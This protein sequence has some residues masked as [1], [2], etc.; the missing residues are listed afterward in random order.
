MLFVVLGCLEGKKLFR[1][2]KQF[3]RRVNSEEKRLV[4]RV[5]TVQ[6]KPRFFGK[7]DTAQR[8]GAVFRVHIRGCSENEKL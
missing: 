6:R 3:R 5:E 1:K 8:M 2:E 7:K 4:K